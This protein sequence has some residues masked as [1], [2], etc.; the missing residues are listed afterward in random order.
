[1]TEAAKKPAQ[2][3]KAKPATKSSEI[4]V[5]AVSSGFYGNERKEAGDE[6]TIKSEKDLGSWMK[7][8]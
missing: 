5:V 6:F 4:D 3:N 7:K 8:A 2:A 1:M